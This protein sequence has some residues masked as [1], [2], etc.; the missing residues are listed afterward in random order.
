[1]LCYSL[2]ICYSYYINEIMY[3]IKKQLTAFDTA[4]EV[5]NLF[6]SVT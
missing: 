3:Y 6:L 5:V 1:M 4:S 2:L